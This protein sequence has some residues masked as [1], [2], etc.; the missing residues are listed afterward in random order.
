[1]GWRYLVR[2]KHSL[3]MPRPRHALADAEQQDVFKK[4]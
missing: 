1:M 3:Q 4:N 2:I